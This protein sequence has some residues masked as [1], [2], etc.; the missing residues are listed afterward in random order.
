[1]GVT[2]KTVQSEPISELEQGEVAGGRGGYGPGST[3][4]DLRP[5]IG[6]IMRSG[7]PWAPTVMPASSS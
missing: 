2:S 4:A 7:A 1:M 5:I 3:R 6:P